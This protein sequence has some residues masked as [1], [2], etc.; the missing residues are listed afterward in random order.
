MS[1]LAHFASISLVS[2]LTQLLDIYTQLVC[3]QTCVYMRRT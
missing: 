1:L 2:Q 3:L